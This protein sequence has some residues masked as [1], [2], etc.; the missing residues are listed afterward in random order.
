MRSQQS[1]HSTMLS[2]LSCLSREIS[3]SVELGTPWSS[4]P[5]LSFLRAMISP[6]SRFL[7]WVMMRAG[8]D[9]MGQVKRLHASRLLTAAATANCIQL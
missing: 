8:V 6:V 7:A 9:I 5:N 1:T 4:N 3:R 2:C